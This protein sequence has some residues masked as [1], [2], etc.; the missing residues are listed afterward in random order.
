MRKTKPLTES[1][2]AVRNPQLRDQHLKAENDD[3]AD[4]GLRLV[5]TLKNAIESGSKEVHFE[6]DAQLCRIRQRVNGQL[7]ESRIE[8]ATLVAELIQE[9][10]K[11]SAVNSSTH[12]RVA[13]N[14]G[15]LTIE[16]E[17]NQE[18]HRLHCTYYPTTS[19]HNLTLK[20][21]ALSYLPETLEQTPLEPSQ[22]QSLRDH[23][24]KNNHGLTL[25]CSPNI[26]LLQ[27][28]YYGLLGDTNCVESKIVSLEYHNAR[29]IP[30][31][32]QL[33]LAGLDNAE[34]I[35]QL[36]TQHADRLF[37]DWQCAR[38]K[39][40]IK[41]VLDNYQSATVF[42]TAQDTN[43]AISQLTDYALNERQLATNLNAL[44]HLDSIRMVCPHC[45]N[46]HEL[47]GAEM[48][49]LEGQALG[50]NSSS[51]FVYAPGCERCDYSGSQTSAP[52]MSVCHVDDTM[53]SAIETRNSATIDKAIQ[54][55]LGKNAVARQI[56]SLVSNGKVS[57]TEYKTR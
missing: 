38:N 56:G 43:T 33:S 52:L 2:N 48:Q 21:S 32:N 24:S 12:N 54:Q 7:D 30:R 18:N 41:N 25:V 9:V 53:R 11:A 8:S 51:V 13:A 35:S 26:E 44:I 22:I 23:F 49:W 50:S 45:A 4:S 27:A 28:L 20:L 5:D 55:K 42:I 14:H 6:Q 31:I 16:L 47:N 17:V 40:L 34:Q 36:A 10:H 46:S 29:D 39:T 57:F 19:G 15:D 1:L 3:V 37:I